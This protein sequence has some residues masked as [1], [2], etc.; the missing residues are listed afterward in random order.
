MAKEDKSLFS[1]IK[2]A[3]KV[4]LADAQTMAFW[5][6]KLPNPVQS[7]LDKL[8][9]DLEKI[10]I[11]ERVSDEE[12]KILI[13]QKVL[14]IKDAS[15]IKE[16]YEKF[17]I[18]EESIGHMMCIGE[19]VFTFCV[20][21]GVAAEIEYLG[22]GAIRWEKRWKEDAALNAPIA[23]LEWL[24]VQGIEKPLNIWTEME[25]A[26][27]EDERKTQEWKSQAPQILWSYADELDYQGVLLDPDKMMEEIK[28]EIPNEKELIS[29]LFKLNGFSSESWNHFS[30][31][32]T[33]PGTI[34]ITFDIN[35]LIEVI[36][37][38][39]LTDSYKEGIAKFFA[40]RDFYQKR[41]KDI[42]H[43]PDNI[44]NILLEYLED[45]GDEDK[46]RQYKK[47][48]MDE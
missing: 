1:S 11:S 36:S 25:N 38:N 9:A 14:E 7:D 45:T 40:S 28:K 21:G 4:I 5:N 42:Q 48:V 6:S 18:I 12:T 19:Y 32:E 29:S 3:G 41:K 8:F 44:K 16:L 39:S 47:R 30:M 13:P 24:F 37:N 22:G 23:F 34:L 26:A 15:K 27:K 20:K 46:I 17:K 33:I 2:K 31:H 43:I 35:S 10:E